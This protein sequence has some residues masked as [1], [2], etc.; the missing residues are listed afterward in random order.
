MPM[1][2]NDGSTRKAC[3]RSLGN[4]SLNAPRK[5]SATEARYQT[6][7]PSVDVL[8]DWRLEELEDLDLTATSDRFSLSTT[9][10][11]P[12]SRSLTLLG[13]QSFMS[14]PSTRLRDAAANSHGP[15]AGISERENLPKATSASVLP[16]DAGIRS[17]ETTAPNTKISGHGISE[18]YRPV[19][20]I[21]IVAQI[22]F[23]HGLMGDS[24][25]SWTYTRLPARDKKYT[26]NVY[27]MTQQQPFWPADFLPHISPSAQILTWDYA[28][29]EGTSVQVCT[30]V[31]AKPTL[32]H[33]IVPK[34]SAVIDDVSYRRI[35]SQLQ[36]WIANVGVQNRLPT[37]DKDHSSRLLASLCGPSAQQQQQ[38][39]ETI[40][41]VVSGTYKWVFDRSQA[42][43]SDWLKE[44]GGPTDTPYWIKGKPGSGKG[45]LISHIFGEQRTLELLEGTSNAPWILHIPYQI[46]IQSPHM[47]V[48]VDQ[49]YQLAVV[50]QGT[51][52]PKWDYPAMDNAMKAVLRQRETSC[53]IALFLDALDEFSSEY[54]DPLLEM[55]DQFRA[56]PDGQILEDYPGLGLEDITIAA[57]SAYVNERMSSMGFSRTQRQTFVD[58]ITTR[59]DGRFIWVT[60]VVRELQMGCSNGDSLPD[61][62]TRLDNVPSGLENFYVRIMGMIQPSYARQAYTMLQVAV[63]A[64]RPLSLKALSSCISDV[65]DTPKDQERFEAQQ[66][67]LT[68]RITAGSGGML[69]VTSITSLDEEID[70]PESLQ[71]GS[72][73]ARPG[74]GRSV[75][76]VQSIYESF[77][78]VFPSLPI[79]GL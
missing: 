66:K 67:T 41:D 46:I 51:N 16:P 15:D 72:Y 30:F 32:G 20:G 39:L 55:I 2:F 60:Q 42:S 59:A 69:E 52:L 79:R 58:K 22:I 49:V 5:C 37:E 53:Q 21:V 68:K 8:S 38:R 56:L 4:Y 3:T 64:L 43:F 25:K 6:S 57:I 26:S 78:E 36:R 18:A 45:T 24:R 1:P 11:A 70:H 63:C 73:A 61:L 19:V 7:S 65:P 54:I 40:T 77:L 75:L 31:E 71:G 10:A 12:S 74:Q 33:V 34:S 47:R 50:K 35:S 23:V 13:N 76:A 27:H 28:L 17:Q 9:L 44:G 48:V 14:L 62:E 29:S